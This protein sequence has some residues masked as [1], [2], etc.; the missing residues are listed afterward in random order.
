MVEKKSSTLRR[1]LCRV[2]ASTAIA[3]EQPTSV[4]IGA[5]TTVSQPP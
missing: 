4:Q 5:A 1:R 2:A 3:G